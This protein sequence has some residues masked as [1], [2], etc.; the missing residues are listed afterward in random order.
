MGVERENARSWGP[1]APL[2]KLGGAHMRP[3][4]QETEGGLGHP[5]LR[6]WELLTRPGQ[7]CEEPRSPNTGLLPQLH[8][9]KIP[10]Y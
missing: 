5:N 1:V 3:T 10:V 4:D 8:P 7:N 6:S 9:R 2:L